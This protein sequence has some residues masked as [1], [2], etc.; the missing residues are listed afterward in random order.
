MS[1]QVGDI[2]RIKIHKKSDGWLQLVD[3]NARFPPDEDECSFKKVQIV[4]CWQ[5]NA[6]DY[7][8]LCDFDPHSYFSFLI[9]AW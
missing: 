7:I 4:G 3:K 8:V 6:N 1:H 9:D 5:M 2:V